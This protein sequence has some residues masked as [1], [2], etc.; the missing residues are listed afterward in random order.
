MKKIIEETGEGLTK[1]LGENITVYCSS[2]IY[3][4]KLLGVNELCIL[5]G[6]TSIVYDT[7]AHAK[8]EFELEEKIPGGDWYV[9]LSH[10][11]SFGKF[12]DPK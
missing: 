1:L 12:K 2:F 11:E 3:A 9:M 4:G 10:I 7:G 8:K 5:L 6:N